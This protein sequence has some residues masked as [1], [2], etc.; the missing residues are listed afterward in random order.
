[1]LLSFSDA[2]AVFECKCADLAMS[3][4]VCRVSSLPASVLEQLAV[5]LGTL[6]L[7]DPDG[8]D[9]KYHERGTVSVFT[10]T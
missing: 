6:S 4:W 2:F 9:P 5:D 3:F 8:G 10:T 7:H 1:M